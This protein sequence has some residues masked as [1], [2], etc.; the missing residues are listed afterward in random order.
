MASIQP[1]VGVVMGS[2]SD[3]EVM[4][5]C[6]KQLDALGIGCEVRILSAHRTPDE[7]A[8]FARTA[9]ERGLK[10]LIAAA[11]MSAAL[12]GSL[13]AQTT[14]PVIGVPMASG[15][16]GG[17]DAALSIM[18]MPPGVPVGCVA[19]GSAG[20]KNAALLAAQILGLSDTSIA[21]AFRR[22]RQEQAKKV[23]EKDKALQSKLA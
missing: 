21:E 1:T 23:R 10:V 11:G 8:E 14:L 6:L 13:A 16:L 18:Q 9:C 3:L 22:F 17:M 4:E 5:S 20:A 12:P 7:A 15:A 2:D 19:I